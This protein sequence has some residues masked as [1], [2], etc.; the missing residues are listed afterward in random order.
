MQQLIAQ[1]LDLASRAVGT[2]PTNARVISIKHRPCIGRHWLL[3]ATDVVLQPGEHRSRLGQRGNSRGRDDTG[4]DM[5]GGVEQEGVGFTRCPT[6]GGDQR[7]T[8]ASGH[9]GIATTYWQRELW[10][11]LIADMNPALGRGNRRIHV[12]IELGG[13]RGNDLKLRGRQTG[14]TEQEHP[15]TQMRMRTDLIGAGPELIGA[16]DHALGIGGHKM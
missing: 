10:F 11:E 2:V 12:H 4:R 15:L 3:I 5:R 9:A 8:D 16:L 1:D 6:P 13:Q 14:Q 7:M